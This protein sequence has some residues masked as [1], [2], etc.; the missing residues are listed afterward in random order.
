MPTQIGRGERRARMTAPVQL[1]RLEHPEAAERVLSE[2]VSSL[3]MRVVGKQR[4]Q[5]GEILLVT[6]LT[7]DFRLP[8]RVVYCKRLAGGRF[9]T[10]LEFQG[11]STKW[12]EDPTGSA[13]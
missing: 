5:P 11:P 8:A 9:A 3:G 4:W 10:G 7:S 1:T 13:A 12:G 6:S 2:N